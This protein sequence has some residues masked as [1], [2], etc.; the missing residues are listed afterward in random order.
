MLRNKRWFG[1]KVIF[2]LYLCATASSAFSRAKL[3]GKVIDATTKLPIVG[4]T[5]SIESEKKGTRTDANGYFSIFLPFGKYTITVSSVGY[6][7]KYRAI[8]L[9]DDITVNF[10]LKEEIKDFEEVIVK[11]RRE[12]ANIKEAQM[13]TVKLNMQAIKKIPV[14]F[15]ET[16]ILKSLTLQAGVSQVGEGAGGLNVRGGRV[17]QNLV[18]LDGAPLFN[19]SHLLGFFSSVN[20]DVVNDVTLYKGAVPSNYGGRLSAILAMNTRTGNNEKVRYSVGMGTVS[21][22]LLAE[23]PVI[24]DKL[25]FVVGSRIAYP[26]LLISYFPGNV[27]QSRAFFY[28]L[29][30][31]AT[32][33]LNK[34]N[35]ISLTGYGSYDDF[36]FP[37]DTAYAWNTVQSTLN[38]N[39]AI[40]NNLSLNTSA[41]LSNYTFDVIG[42]KSGLGFRLRS[43]IQQKEFK[44]SLFYSKSEKSKTDFGGGFTLYNLSP[45][46]QRPTNAESNVISQ[47]LASEAA[48]EMSVFFNQE[49]EFLKIFSIQAGLRYTFFQNLGAKTVYQYTPLQQILPENI[50]DSVRYS[51]GD[52]TKNYGGFEPRVS[53]R[54]SLGKTASIKLSFNRMKQYINLISNTAAISP[55]DFWKLSDTYIPP[56]LSDQ[57]SFGL[58]KNFKDNTYETSIEAYYK[59]QKD[60]VE[61][62]KGARLIKNPLLETA[63]LPAIGKNYGVEFTIKKNKGDFTGIAS[64]TYA[65]SLIAVTTPFEI[66]QVNDGEFYPANFDKPHTLNISVLYNLGHGL[67]ISSNFTYNTGRPITFPDGA[68]SF[69]NLPVINYSKRNLD[70]IPDFHRLDFSL[71]YD[72][73][74]EK[75]QKHYNLW[76]LSF[77]NIYG[78][79]NPY[80]VYFTSYNRVTRPFQLSVFGSIIPSLTCNINF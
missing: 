72:T 1:L 32:Y 29:N 40:N 13:G 23:G 57:Y 8:D 35:R 66:E 58:F 73:R 24:K 21:A 44:T 36:K 62:K 11:G 2:I 46:V 59:D 31:K 60:L 16:D 63:L 70:R 34:K 64:Y 48:R 14:A 54:M 76:V 38:W 47:T 51:A 37:E 19:T 65:R 3:D 80:S 50:I 74:R 77:Y 27:G 69:N 71:S 9:N 18:M 10:E 45:A 75:D 5:I 56:Q 39:Y 52:V 42:L 20:P 41:L 61:Y 17:D 68:Y 28:D 4:A 7:K 78:R 67:N 15:G 26:N 79:Q 49:Y 43:A 33:T 22:R 12:D 30:A 6:Y 53:L 55:V 25:T